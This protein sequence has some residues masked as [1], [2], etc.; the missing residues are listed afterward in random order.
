MNKFTSRALGRLSLVIGALTPFGVVF[1]TLFFIGE[2]NQITALFYFGPASDVITLSITILTCVMA[3]MLLPSPSKQPGSFIA[4]LL[5]VAAAWVG[6][7]LVTVD[8]LRAGNLMPGNIYYTL[9]IKYGLVFLTDSNGVFGQGLVGLWLTAVNIYACT[10]KFWPRSITVLG[11]VSGAIAL[12]GLFDLTIVYLGVA[13][14]LV[15]NILLG[16]WILG[17]SS[18]ESVPIT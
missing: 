18:P 16:R 13:G 4:F 17:K 15:W 11:I 6:A 2:F 5:L 8:S 9:R 7:A 10:K 3:V 12:L 14:Q 1:L